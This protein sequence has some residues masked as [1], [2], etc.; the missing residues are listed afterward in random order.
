MCTG[1]LPGIYACGV[2]YQTQVAQHSG[3]H[4]ECWAKVDTMKQ[5]KSYETIV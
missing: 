1:G 4:T 2:L 5:E 3:P